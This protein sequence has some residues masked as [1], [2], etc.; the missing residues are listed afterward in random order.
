M[1]VPV[2]PPESEDIAG[3]PY[4]SIIAERLVSCNAIF[5]FLVKFSSFFP[6]PRPSRRAPDG[7]FVKISCKRYFFHL[8]ADRINTNIVPRLGPGLWMNRVPGCPA[9]KMEGQLM[10]IKGTE[11]IL[12][13]QN[14]T[15]RL[16]AP[17]GGKRVGRQSSRYDHISLSSPA[18]LEKQDFQNAV[19]MLSQQVRTNTSTGKIQ[20]LHRLV[21]SGEYRV[22][23]REVAARM[24]L[25][26]EGE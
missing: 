10:L 24:L 2:F 8:T 25:L 23:P 4:G 7:K 26:E 20:E 9:L 19:A 3:N 11:G 5:L 15:T 22:D 13:F 21:S 1:L 17:S 18:G 16:A 12:P 6:L 14:S